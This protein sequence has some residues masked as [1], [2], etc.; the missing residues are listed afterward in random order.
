MSRGRRGRAQGDPGAE[1]Q[2]ASRAKRAAKRLQVPLIVA[3]LLAIPTI[4]VQ[5]TDIGRFWDSLA[6]VLDW[7]I[8]AMFAAN[9]VI[10]LSLVLDRR[11]WPNASCTAGTQAQ[12]L[13]RTEPK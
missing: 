12:H 7:C 2:A 4:I 9:L 13:I 1:T 11:R 5:E 6:A 3:A 8:W 10:M